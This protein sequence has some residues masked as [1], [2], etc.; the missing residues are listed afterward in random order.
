[1]AKLACPCGNILWNGCDGDETVYCFV[2]DGNLREHWEDTAFFEMQ[3]NELGVEIWK[4][5][6]CDRMMVFDPPGNRVTRYLLRVGT[7]TLPV[8]IDGGIDGLV[9]NNLLFNELD[10]WFTCKSSRGDCPEY[11][12]FGGAAEVERNPLLTPKIVCDEVLSNKNG[13]FRNWWYACLT[14]DLLV[15]YSPYDPERITPVKA[16]RRYEQNWEEG[17]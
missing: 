16:W 4:C 15:F 11:E 2:S 14:K 6:V 12:F 3:Y 1:M 13:R 7:D 5:D 9:W 8:R 17:K 10:S